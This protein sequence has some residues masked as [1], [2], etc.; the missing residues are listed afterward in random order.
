MDGL[1]LGRACTLIALLG[2]LAAPG[3]FAQSGGDAP[4]ALR[5]VGADSMATF[6]RGWA[7]GFERTTPGVRVEIESRGSSTGPPALL[8]GRAEIASMSRPMNDSEIEAFRTRFGHEPVAVVVAIDALAVFVHPRNPLS[9]LSLPQLDA[10]FSAKPSCGGAEPA[11]RWGDLGVEGEYADRGIGLYGPGPRSG[12]R[13]YFRE[14]VLCGERFRDTLRSKPGARS[15]AMSVADSP[16]GIGVGSQTGRVPGVKALALAPVAA[17][18]YATLSA[19]EVYSRAYPLGR[20]LFFYLAPPGEQGRDP[21]VV[22]FVELALSPAGQSAVEKAGYLRVPEEH[23]EG[24]L[25]KL[26]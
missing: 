15:I 11:L 24:Q 14:R 2:L 1:A 10:V 16:F 3:T 19:A 5:I 6:L 23:L 8:T 18:P 25:Q 13:G 22:A 17:E 9:E 7:R 20:P 21:R 12:A 4:A 26:R